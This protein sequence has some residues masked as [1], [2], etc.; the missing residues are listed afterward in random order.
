MYQSANGFLTSRT[1][2]E[3]F[4]FSLYELSQLLER[5]TGV[6]DEPTCCLLSAPKRRFRFFIS[7]L[8]E[9]GSSLVAEL[10]SWKE[11]KHRERR[12]PERER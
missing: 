6:Y 3:I 11:R 4:K 2:D 5:P 12:V 8:L 1:L 9:I 10:A 7:S